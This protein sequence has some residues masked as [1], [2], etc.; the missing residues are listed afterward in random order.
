M[1][2]TILNRLPIKPDDHAEQSAQQ[3]EQDRLDEELPE[4]VGAARADRFADADLAGAFGHRHQH[5]VHHAD[6]ADE[7][8]D[9]GDRAEQHGEDLLVELAVDSNVAWFSTWKSACVGSV[10]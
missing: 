3:A 1:T 2:P 5:D 4:D 8:R 9:R 7:Q 6:A 10:M